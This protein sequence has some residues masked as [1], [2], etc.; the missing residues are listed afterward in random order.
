MSDQPFIPALRFEALTRFYDPAVGL[1]TRESL[2][3]A[4][5]VGQLSPLP[6]QKILDLGCGSGTLA[7]ELCDKEP[8]A[9]VTGLDADPEI[10]K[11][12]RAKAAGRAGITF[13]EGFSNDLPY[14]DSAFDA[15]VSTLF[16]H[17]LSPE[18]RR[19]TAAELVRVL[20]PGGRLHVADWD[21]PASPLMRVLSLGIRLLDGFEATRDNF[22]GRLPGIL[23]RAGFT[24]VARTGMT[25]TM[26]GTIGLL[27][28]LG[29]ETEPGAGADQ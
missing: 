17:H 24:A 6:G 29:P 14:E 8:Q 27:E 13:D 28:A 10:L 5:I 21:R 3:K 11:R 9:R 22:A 15:V 26:F 23:E 7:I 2:F 12:A 18:T 25:P 1:T 16:F 4:R 19:E 20:R